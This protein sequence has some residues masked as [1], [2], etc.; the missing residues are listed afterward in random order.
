MVMSPENCRAEHWDTMCFTV[1]TVSSG[2]RPC[3]PTTNIHHTIGKQLM[4]FTQHVFVP[5]Q[6]KDRKSVEVDTDSVL[7]WC[8]SATWPLASVCWLLWCAAMSCWPCQP[9][10]QSP[11]S[12]RGTGLAHLGTRRQD[13]AHDFLPLKCYWNKRVDTHPKV[14]WH[15]SS[16]DGR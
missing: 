16:G 7:H 15:Y 2:G 4:L 9:V 13:S 11:Q 6:N 10:S 1:F 3:L 5:S 14:C 8:W 12:P